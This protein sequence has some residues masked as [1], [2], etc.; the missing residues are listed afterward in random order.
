MPSA[1]K[2]DDLRIF[3]EVARQGSVHAASKRLKLD[4]STV[5]PANWK[6]RIPA[7]GEASRPQPEG[8]RRSARKRRRCSSISSRWICTPVSLED[9]VTRDGQ[10]VDSDG[11]HRDDG[12]PRQP[13]SGPVPAGAFAIRAQ[14]KDRTRQHPA[15]GRSH[16][17]GSRHLPELL[18]P[19]GARA[20]ERPVRQGFTVSVLLARLR[21]P[22]RP[23]EGPQ[24]SAE[25]RIRWIHRRSAG[26]SR[27]PMAGRGYRQADDELSQQQ[28]HRAMQR[29]GVWAGYRAVADIRGGGRCGTAT[30]FCPDI[31]VRREIW[32]SI[33][34][35]QS[36]LARESKPSCSF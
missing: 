36:H 31:V 19:K 20:E 21:A 15:N 12:R 10:R 14:R 30:T 2:W 11:P 28:H 22:T 7:L 4:H 3:L 9:T 18:Q 26:H 6:A 29:R 8:H 25:A 1:A 35:E 27:G 16:A 32:V 13:L 23:S 17:K 24:G 5:T 33:R 34:T